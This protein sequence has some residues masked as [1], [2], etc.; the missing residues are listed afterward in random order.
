MVMGLLKNKRT[1]EVR[2]S[3][4]ALLTAFNSALFGTTNPAY[5]R[6]LEVLQNEALY[7]AA[8]IIG[9]SIAGL[10]KNLYERTERGPVKRPDYNLQKVLRNPNPNTTAFSF[11]ETMAVL[12]ALHGNSY[13]SMSR[14]PNTGYIKD[15]TILDPEKI[16]PYIDS[17]GDKK[18]RNRVTGKTFDKSQILHISGTSYNGLEGL[19]PIQLFKRQIAEG[20]GADEYI[21]NFF[22]KGPLTNIILTLP[23]GYAEDAE[24]KP[25]DYKRR[26]RTMKAAFSRAFGGLKNQGEPILLDAG[27]KHEKI[28]QATNRDN[29]VL[30]LR[31]EAVIKIARIYRIPPHMLMHLADATYSNITQQS[32]DYYKQCALPWIQRFE[33]AINAQLLPTF[34]QDTIY[35]KFN[36]SSIL[37][38]TDEERKEFY[39]AMFN[40]GAMS[41]NEIRALEE[42]PRLDAK[43][44]DY[45][46]YNLGYGFIEKHAPAGGNT[47]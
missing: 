33:A 32:A 21:V 36:A 42:L 16:E 5:W 9:E 3:T 12:A 25:E 1:P 20:L 28:D 19:S 24:D 29:Q 6:E 4:S 47:E 39:T 30:E 27:F 26:I 14:W 7:T 2:T 13:A 41:I 38:G 17:S 43:A 31:K 8:K 37:R 45:H 46:A 18:F 22:T 23:E 10:P 34:D 44:A 11:W 35:V 40:I 15:L